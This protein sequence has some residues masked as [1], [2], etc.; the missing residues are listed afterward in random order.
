MTVKSCT[1]KIKGRLF[2]QE[3]LSPGQMQR[4]SVSELW[5]VLSGE[6]EGMLD[7]YLPPSALCDL[8]NIVLYDEQGRTDQFQ[9][10]DFDREI[11]LSTVEAVTRDFFLFNPE[12]SSRLIGWT[13]L[14]Q[15]LAAAEG[16][17][18]QPGQDPNSGNTSASVPQAAILPN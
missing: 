10:E 5:T 17:V 6:T 2:V 15:A 11:K 13:G 16:Q 14:L 12:F 4:I 7:I 9:I 3:E 1:Y 8:F 18:P